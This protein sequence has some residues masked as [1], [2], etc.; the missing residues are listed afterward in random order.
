ML[1]LSP[2]DAKVIYEVKR[3]LMQKGSKIKVLAKIESADR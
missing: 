2:Q 3:W 1:L